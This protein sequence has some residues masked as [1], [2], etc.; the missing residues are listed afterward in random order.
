MSMYLIL[1]ISNNS[2]V[3]K[4]DARIKYQNDGVIKK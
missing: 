2:L 4:I 3:S 1:Q